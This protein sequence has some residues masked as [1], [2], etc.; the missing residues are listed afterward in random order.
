M[1]TE[2]I[3]A[4][5]A[6]TT[7]TTP[8]TETAPT[9][10]ASP[11]VEDKWYSKFE[12][13]LIRGHAEVKGW[14]TAEDAVKS[15]ME[16]EKFLGAPKEELFHLP[17]D[18]NTET[19][20]PLYDKLGRPKDIDGYELSQ[21][22]E[23]TDWFKS[24]AHKNGLTK[25]QAQSMAGAYETFETEFKA[26]NETEA[27]IAAESGLKDLRAKW[28]S[29]YEKNESIAKDAVREFGIDEATIEGI[30][31]TLGF[32][33]TM[34]LFAQIG[35]KIGEHSFNTG[36]TNNSGVLSPDGAIA[37]KEQLMQDKDFLKK[38]QDGDRKSIELWSNLNKMS[39]R[40]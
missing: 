24:V 22:G 32:S 23:F 16:A 21:K 30:E 9:T 37:K 17:K 20:L 10:T 1:K 12:D 28:G 15:Y 19:L 36:S 40:G 25:E 14:K 18:L 3:T 35:S 5:A 38:M 8:A 39:L 6:L 34:D 26:A 31:K 13:S 27:R 7:E 29:A 2:N 33:A 4:T 11:E